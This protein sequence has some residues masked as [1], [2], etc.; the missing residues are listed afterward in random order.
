ML[1]DLFTTAE[2]KNQL[3]GGV[4]FIALQKTSEARSPQVCWQNDKSSP[5]SL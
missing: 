5:Q 4:Q 1:K 3:G 2:H